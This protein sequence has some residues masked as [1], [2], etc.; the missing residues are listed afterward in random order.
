MTSNYRTPA[1]VGEGNDVVQ[2][3]APDRR[4]HSHPPAAMA[5]EAAKL[6]CW[7]KAAWTAA[8]T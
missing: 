4:R 7:A 8:T 1:G 5:A 2:A 6:R 3:L